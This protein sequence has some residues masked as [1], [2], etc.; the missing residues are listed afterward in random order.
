MDDRDE[1]VNIIKD[2]SIIT[3]RQGDITY[4]VGVSRFYVINLN[5]H[6]AQ[7]YLYNEIESISASSN[8]PAYT[9]LKAP[10][11]INTINISLK[12]GEKIVIESSQ[13]DLTDF[14]DAL[15]TS[16]YNAAVNHKYV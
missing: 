1:I 16:R 9:D 6:K 2:N 13:K 14:N 15:I 5:N 11:P 3:F 8:G 12:T 4:A 10:Q 7:T